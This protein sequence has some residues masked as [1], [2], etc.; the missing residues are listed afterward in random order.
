MIINVVVN[1]KGDSE[2]EGEHEHD[3]GLLALLLVN[4]IALLTMY[5]KSVDNFNF[6]RSQ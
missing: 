2:H 4:M 3:L 6:N 1:V 5:V